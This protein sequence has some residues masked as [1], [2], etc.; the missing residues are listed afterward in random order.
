MLIKNI[1]SIAVA[2]LIVH[3]TIAQDIQFTQ[4]YNV[5]LSLN[6]ALAG[7]MEKNIRISL[8][9]KNQWSQVLRG[10]AYNAYNLSLDKKINLKNGDAFGVGL[11]G[12]VDRIGEL[13]FGTTQGNLSFA[14]HKN[15][16][17]DSLSKHTLSF[18]F[19]FGIAQRKVDHT[20]ARWP[21]QHDG[22][23]GMTIDHSVGFNPEFL[24]PDLNLGLNW[25][26]RL[27]DDFSF[28]IGGAARHLNQPN[29]SFYGD[30]TDEALTPRF[31]IHGEANWKTGAVMR[32]IPRILYIKQGEYS[33]ITPGLELGFDLGKPSMQIG[34]YI[35]THNE[36]LGGINAQAFTT[37]FSMD[38]GVFRFGLSY[39][40]PTSGDRV[41]G[42]NNGAG[43]LTTAIQF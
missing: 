22:N 21:S 41:A 14:Y 4:F 19:E 13:N 10:D 40:A 33:E 6:P 35:R 39:E 26:S 15:I 8:N 25:T 12:L 43:E 24:Y 27:T 5:P 38:F 34:H 2:L 1:L 36:V 18:A 17:N 37:V 32:I 3:S 30:Q 9:H 29:I 23:G 31:T 28:S 20:N 42:G 16:G 11:N 7:S